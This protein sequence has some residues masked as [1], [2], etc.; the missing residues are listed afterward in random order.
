MP[1]SLLR[2]SPP[3]RL[4]SAL[5][6]LAC[7]NSSVRAQDTASALRYKG[8]TLTPVGFIA[9]EALWRSRNITADVPSAYNA[10]PFDGTSAAALSEFRATS[11]QSRFGVLA[12]GKENGNAITG[13]MEM[14]FLGVGIAS[15]S[16][17]TNSYVVRI[18]QAW[19]SLTTA[20]KLTFAGGQMWSLLTTNKTGMLPRSED[21]P[22]TIEAQFVPG[23]NWA[24][25]TAFRV[26]QSGDV[27][28]VGVALEGAQTT[29]SSRNTPANVLVGQ[30][31]GGFLNSAANYSIDPTPDLIAKVA[32]D[33]KGWGHWEVKG[34]ARAMRDRFVDPT[35]TSGGT[36]N[37]NTTGLAVGIGSYVPVVVDK[38]TVVDI[39]LS[40][41]YGKGIGRYGTSQLPDATIDADGSLKPITAAHALLS[42]ETHPTSQLD[43]Y[44][45]GG[46]EYE[47]RA[48]FVTPAGKGGGYGSPLNGNAGCT[49]ETPPAGPF[50]P[51]SAAPCNADT[52][53]IYQGTLGFW[54]RFYK[55]SSGTVQWGLQFSHTVRTTWAGLGSQPQGSENMVFSSFRFVLP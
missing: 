51:A 36:R 23:F 6:A 7:F 37:L 8:L 3:A 26:V 13:L 31:G 54:Y 14:D 44:G 28:S 21:A 48:D 50:I 41:L 29:F 4:A 46:V 17:E 30:P 49:A 2:V 15:T 12:Q 27:A 32:I 9:A 34:I 11:R 40:A 22:M 52:R 25:Q 47:D 39:G 19:A 10:I 35:S 20:N 5:L 38:R 18:R 45:Y 16:N 43:V 24:R 55:G 53:N 42:V 1:N 33:P